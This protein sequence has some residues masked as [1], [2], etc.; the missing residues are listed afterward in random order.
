MHKKSDLSVDIQKISLLHPAPSE[1]LMKSSSGLFLLFIF[2]PSSS[3]RYLTQSSY[4][5]T[6]ARYLPALNLEFLLNS[7]RIS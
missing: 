4:T 6:A 3:L 1:K 5:L 2:N 7:R